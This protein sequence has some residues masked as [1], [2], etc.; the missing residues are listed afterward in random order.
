M[1]RK[2]ATDNDG[3]LCGENEANEQCCFG[4]DQHADHDVDE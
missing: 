4:E 2:H 1:A 3:G